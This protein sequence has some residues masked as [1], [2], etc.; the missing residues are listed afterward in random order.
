MKTIRLFIISIG[1]LAMLSSCDVYRRDILF[2]AT[3]EMEKEFAKNSTNTKTPPNYLLSKN[4]LLEFMIFTNKGEAIIDP[5]SELMKQV[6][7][8][9][10][11]GRQGSTRYLIQ[12]DG[13]A[14]L[15]ILGHT[16]LDSLTIHQIDSLLAVKY[17]QFYQDVF[18]LSKVSNRKVFILGLGGGGSLGAGMVGAMGGGG[19]GG[20]SSRA[21]IVELESENVTLIEIL[22]KS[23][24]VGRYSYANRIKVIRGDL[25]NPQIFS[26]DLT[27]WNSYQKANLILQPNDIVY[28]E[29]LR[30]GFLEFFSDITSLSSILT[31]VLSVYLITR[32]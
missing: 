22:A 18:V 16:K 32:L 12:G 17:G 10:N 23:G 11:A 14:D 9:G 25:K 31:T 28:I 27:K 19:M 13:C 7:V 30:R 4:D 26:I 1:I 15:P 6:S 29:P 3:K 8:M 20:G 24:G 2:K 21:S 5:T